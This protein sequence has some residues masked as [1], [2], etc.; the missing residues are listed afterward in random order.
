MV[1]TT[2]TAANATSTLIQS[3]IDAGISFIKWT[4]P[5]IVTI[6]AI[7]YALLL[8]YQDNLLYHPNVPGMPKEPQNN[9]VDYR[10][11]SEYSKKGK[12]YRKYP[13]SAGP[14][15]F[16][17]VTLET[18]DGTKL[19]AWLLLQ[20]NSH[21]KPTLIYFHG[22]AANMGWRLP[23]AA[24]MYAIA[25]INILMVDYRGFGNSVGTPTEEG[26][27][28]DGETA[29]L[30]V[31]KHSK[32]TNSKVICFGRSLGLFHISYNNMYIQSYN[33][34]VYFIRVCYD[35]RI[36]GAVAISLAQKY[37]TL[38][39]AII[40]EN[41]FLSIS[42]MVDVLMPFLSVF[43]SLVL[44][45]KWDSDVKIQQL[46]QPTLFISGDS[47]TLVPPP[48]MKKLYE[49]SGSSVKDFYS[50]IG[51]GHNDAFI[52]AGM[53][54]Y[55]RLKDFVA[56]NCGS[57]SSSNGGGSS[58]IDENEYIEFDQSYLPTMDSN[59]RVKK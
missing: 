59:F 17:D 36:G 15:P 43:K 6:S 21:N 13:D 8:T 12:L 27:N 54:Y 1:T 35:T 33:S 39:H 31:K 4:G 41:T 45:I 24:L 46:R 42:S 37:P 2:D 16:E 44:R 34:L 5:I 32:L 28:I 7:I 10:Q 30:F 25:D 29:L 14:I 48:Q 51:G 57:C 49:L 11:P 18:V 50:I 53:T 3:T 26:L 9:P 40:I 47:D 56:A 52:T 55:L 38:V 19:H 22:N 58:N 20:D 23:N